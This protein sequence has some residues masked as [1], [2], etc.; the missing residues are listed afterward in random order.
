VADYEKNMG[1]AHIKAAIPPLQ[2]GQSHSFSY[3]IHY[4][5]D[6]LLPPLLAV[7]YPATVKQLV[8]K[9]AFHPDRQPV[10]V[11]FFERVP[12]VMQA[13]GGFRSENVLEPF[14]D[15]SYSH[16]LVMSRRKT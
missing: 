16:T 3:H 12:T 14:P 11:W 2:A 9:A 15:G 5:G 6:K 4:S 1:V 7:K 8:A 13:P 10:V